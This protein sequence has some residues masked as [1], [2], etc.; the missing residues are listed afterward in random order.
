IIVGALA[1]FIIPIDAVADFLP[2]GYVDDWGALMGA[3]WAVARHVKQE[4]TERAR[5]KLREWF[6]EAE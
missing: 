3:F 1:Y 5:A 6:P 4:H 2:G